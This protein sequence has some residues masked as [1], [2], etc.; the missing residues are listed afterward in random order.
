MTGVR[1]EPMPEL[2]HHDDPSWCNEEC[3]AKQRRFDEWIRNN[4]KEERM[5][6]KF[7]Q[8]LYVVRANEGTRDEFY[9]ADTSILPLAEKGETIAMAV[10]ELAG[11][12]KVTCSPDAAITPR[13]RPNLKR[14][15]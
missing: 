4:L 8:K 5:A 7:P 13:R 15:K 11:E 3:E 14:V 6:K 10:Y 1:R 9:S 12:G 2:C